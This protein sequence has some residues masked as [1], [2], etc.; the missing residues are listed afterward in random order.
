MNTFDD[1][2]QCVQFY[3]KRW[4]IEEFHRMLK[5]GCQVESLAHK[6]VTRITRALAVYM[7]VA[8]RLMLLL[9]LGREL[10]DLSPEV[11]LDDIEIRVLKTIFKGKKARPLTTLYDAIVLIAKLGGYLD[12]K[13]DPP[14][15]YEVF[16]KGYSTFQNMCDYAMACR[17]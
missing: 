3:S 2:Y 4:G 11:L 12:R 13:N 17:E 16:W 14:P 10:P 6:D 9:K 7:V 15:G 1:A 8:C 5:T